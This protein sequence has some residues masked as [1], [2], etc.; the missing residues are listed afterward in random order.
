M[1][2]LVQTRCDELK[3][4]QRFSSHRRR[5]RFAAM[6]TTKAVIR[7]VMTWAADHLDE[8]LAVEVLARRAGY[9]TPYFSRAFAAVVG[10]SPASWILSKRV[11]RAAERL[12]SEGSRVVDVA[13]D[14]GFNDVTTFARAFRRRTGLTPSAFRRARNGA[15]ARPELVV[16]AERVRLQAFRLSGLAV[17]VHG[18]PTGP[19]ALW[20]RLMKL[21]DDMEMV[22]APEDFCQVAFWQGDPEMAYTCVAGFRHEGNAPPPLPFVS[23]DI[24]AATCRRFLVDDAGQRIGLAYEMIFD[25]LLPQLRDRPTANFVCELPRADGREGVEIW[26]PVAGEPARG[27]T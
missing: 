17:D 7:E 1:E 16:A 13:L 26:L 20:Q 21:I 10:E 22:V 24:P 9:S 11:E 14:C 2:N 27:G 3:Q 23:I 19:A 12:T 4:D 15:E 8:D 25:T 5:P 6:H 18:D